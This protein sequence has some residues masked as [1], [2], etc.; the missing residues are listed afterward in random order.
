VRTIV[1][2]KNY[3]V[4]DRVRAYAERK[5]GR[6]DRLLDDRSDAI[7]E[8]SVERHRNDADSHVVDITLVVDGQ[9]VRGRA[10]APTHQAGVDE[11]LDKVERQAV[12]LRE[13]PRDRARTLE[14]EDGAAASTDA[15]DGRGR[16]VKVKRF[17]I[18]PMFAEDAVQQMEELGHSF[19]VFVDAETERIAILYRRQAGDYGVI[20]PMM[21]GAYTKGGPVRS[22]GSRSSA[23]GTARR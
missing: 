3:E 12:G 22:S 5:L 16:I 11:V 8:L 18:E 4:P 19:F 6:L 21:G 1:K 2:G 13:K 7:V 14:L 23:S 9:T 20:E 17:A 15:D 10:T